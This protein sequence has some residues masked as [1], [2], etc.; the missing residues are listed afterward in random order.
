MM[1]LAVCSPKTGKRL[2][3]QEMLKRTREA[4]LGAGLPDVAVVYIATNYPSSQVVRGLRRSIESLRRAVGG[5]TAQV[6]P[7]VWPDLA[8]RYPSLSKTVA[9]AKG[10]GGTYV[11]IVE[12]YVC[13]YAEWGYLPTFPST[14]DE[15]V[16]HMREWRGARDGAELAAL[17]R[18][19]VTAMFEYDCHRATRKNGTKRYECAGEQPG[20]T[21]EFRNR[22]KN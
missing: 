5:G 17:M 11:S 3:M 20:T 22:K 19:K 9:A 18:A 14:W 2:T 8:T 10:R 1:F 6:V 15:H 4:S 7:V 21:L 13:A 12:Q 16:I